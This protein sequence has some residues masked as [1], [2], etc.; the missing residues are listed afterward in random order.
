MWIKQRMTWLTKKT[1]IPIIHFRNNCTPSSFTIIYSSQK[2]TAW[3]LKI[4][5]W[6]IPS[7]WKRIIFRFPKVR[8]VEKPSWKLTAIPWKLMIGRCGFPF[9][10]YLFRGHL[11]LVGGFNPFQKSQLGSS[12]QVGVKIKNTWNHQLVYLANNIPPDTSVFF[13]G[14]WGC[15]IFKHFQHLRPLGPT[16]SQ[17]IL[18]APSCTGNGTGTLRRFGSPQLLIPRRKKS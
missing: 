17:P 10:W 18:V 4:D 14:F 11:S 12:P 6:K 5:F 9:K 13:N 1:T 16:E 2:L 15:R 3:N 8:I 7:F